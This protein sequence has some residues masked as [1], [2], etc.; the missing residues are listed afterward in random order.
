MR[1]PEILLRRLEPR[2]KGGSVSESEHAHLTWRKSKAS[3]N[4]GGCVEIA[5]SAESVHVRNSR[6]INGPQLV[7][8]H[9][10]WAAFLVG[11]RN[12]EFEL[13]ASPE[14]DD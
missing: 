8:L 2:S 3:G 13:S 14:S 9:P 5:M 6:N 11:V 1:V 4:S 12:G 7:F 10:E